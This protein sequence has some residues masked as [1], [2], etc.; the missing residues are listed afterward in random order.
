MSYT[1]RNYPIEKTYFN[2][3]CFNT[4]LNVSLALDWSPNTLHAGFYLAK[5]K[6][7]YEESGIH[8]ELVNPETDNYR[9]TPAK[10]LSNRTVHFAIAPTESVLSYRTFS[11][12][13]P[14]VA[15]AALLQEDTSAIVTL[16]DKSIQ[17]PKDLDG[18]VYASYGARY[19]DCIVKKMIQNDGGCGMLQI[20]NP[21]KLG[22][23]DTLL[24]G[25]ADATWVFMP[26]EGVE[27]QQKNIALNAFKLED[28]NI[29]Y[30]YS[31]LLLSHEA[32]LNEYT[33]DVKRFLKI[34]ADGYDFL[35]KN[36]SESAQFLHDNLDHPNFKNKELIENSL[37]ML[38][39]KWL[40]T[41]SSW[42]TMDESVWLKFIEW[43]KDKDVLCNLDGET[44]SGL[45]L[46]LEELYTN[47]YLPS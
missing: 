32:V 21:D 18:K 17:S 19:E 41:D 24:N 15:V 2:Y 14:L 20:S 3:L 5:L 38:S 36:P 39:D 28:Y 29:P 1:L 11:S 47:Q 25:Q 37:D 13:V 16:K 30:G 34:T 43:L 35:A 8:L 40:H 12:K 22:I 46:N 42:G 45:S 26:W 10:R 23:W 6:G 44:L 4:M 9:L 27:A 31:P 33:D 7:W